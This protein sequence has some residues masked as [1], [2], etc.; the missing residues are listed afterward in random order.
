[1]V[2]VLQSHGFWALVLLASIPNPAFDLCGMCCGTFQMA[3]PTFLGG[4]LAGKGLVKPLWQCA[5]FT[6]IFHVQTRAVFADRVGGIL[7]MVL[8]PSAQAKRRLHDALAALSAPS[9][10]VRLH[11]C[12][13]CPPAVLTSLLTAK[14]RGRARQSVERLSCRGGALLQHHMHRA[15]CAGARLT[16]AGG[17]AQEGDAQAED[18]EGGPFQVVQD[19]LNA[20]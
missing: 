15:N 4:V 17:R 5:L 1:M 9:R 8:P 20:H 14:A 10:G 7:Q 6:I 16:D 12:A 3:L 13:L 19:F 18:A 2:Y 11:A